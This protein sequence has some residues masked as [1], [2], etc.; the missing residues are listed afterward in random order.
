MQAGERPTSVTG[1]SRLA[2][3]RLALVLGLL[4][5]VLLLVGVPLAG[6]AHEW[7]FTGADGIVI[8]PP[9]AIVGFV[10]ARRVP[11]NPIGWSLLVPA[12]AAMLSEDAGFYAV[13]AVRLGDHGLPLARVAVFLA[14]GWAWL[15]L[16]LPLP[17]ALFP[18]GK[19]PRRWRWTTPAFLTITAAFVAVLAWKDLT[20]VLAHR[21]EVDSAGELAV[22]SSS[23]SGWLAYCIE[24]YV[25]LYAVFS[26]AWVTRLVLRYRQ[27]SG[28]EREQLKWF[29]AGGTVCISAMLIGLPLGDNTAGNIAW[30]A[31]SALPAGIGIGVLK[32]RL[33]EI[34][35]LISRTISYLIITALL[36]GIFVAIVALTTHVLPFSSPVGVAAS[37][38]TAAALFNPLRL[39]VQRLVDR[40][41]NRARY[42]TEAIVT[43]FT[44]RLRDA[45]DLDT[46]RDELLQAVDRAVEP[47]HASVWLRQPKR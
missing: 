8:I 33:Y 30:I 42:D 23:Q 10:L 41:F 28:A 40:R 27:A 38:L 6:L 47:V 24:L 43:A 16:L 36:A 3:A 29:F 34:D 4:G 25:P 13:R 21:I 18:D 15:I 7:T 2:D 12:V 39:R 37:T 31:I 17:I 19:L 11:R 20:G 32:Y 46:I 44:L 5:L 22:F 45:V 9:F 1:W 14:A 35:K 26:L